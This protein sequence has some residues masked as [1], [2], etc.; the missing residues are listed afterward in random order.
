MSDVRCVSVEQY[1]QLQAENE[2]LRKHTQRALDRFR[3]E[4]TGRLNVRDGII[5]A[6][7]DDLEQALKGGEK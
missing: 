5:I 3:K 1:E 2:R 6:M 4:D 7:V